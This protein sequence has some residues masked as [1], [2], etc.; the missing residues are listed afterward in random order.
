[1]GNY[2][3]M[4]AKFGTLW[5]VYGTQN[6]ICLNSPTDKRKKYHLIKGLQRVLKVVVSSYHWEGLT[7]VLVEALKLSQASG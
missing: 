5:Q 3:L 6:L 7:R 4:Q 2:N 1:M